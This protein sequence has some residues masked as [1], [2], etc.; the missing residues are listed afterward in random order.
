MPFSHTKGFMGQSW[1]IRCRESEDEVVIGTFS[2]F[3][4]KKTK[5]ITNKIGSMAKID[6]MFIYSL[7][8]S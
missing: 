4:I 5:C 2:D 3:L 8:E 1:R 6:F 7:E